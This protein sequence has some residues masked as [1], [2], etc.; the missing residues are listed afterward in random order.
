MQA[1]KPEQLAGSTFFCQ[2]G[3]LISMWLEAGELHWGLATCA[4]HQLLQSDSHSPNDL[5]PLVLVH[6]DF[7]RTGEPGIAEQNTPVA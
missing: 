7:F 5:L 1:S 6:I 4:A 3:C 2:C